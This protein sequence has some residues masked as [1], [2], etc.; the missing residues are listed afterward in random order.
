MK[1]T[2]VRIPTSLLKEI[3]NIVED[4]PEKGYTNEHEFIREAL[5]EKLDRV[6]ESL[7]DNP[8]GASP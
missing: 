3:T 4:H 8:K 2:P 7:T 5:R 6:N 1:W